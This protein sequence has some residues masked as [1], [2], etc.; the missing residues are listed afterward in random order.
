MLAERG[1]INGGFREKGAVG[2]DWILACHMRGMG[3]AEGDW[4]GCCLWRWA[5][6]GSV[7]PSGKPRWAGPAMSGKALSAPSSWKWAC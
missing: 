4:A 5:D 7:P 6:R 3:G 2:G 1:A